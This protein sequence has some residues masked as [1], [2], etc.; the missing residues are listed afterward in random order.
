MRQKIARHIGVTPN[1]N[2]ASLLMDFF[3]LYGNSFNYYQTGVSIINGGSYFPKR[4]RKANEAF[5]ARYTTAHC[6]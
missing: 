6:L 4:M 3:A 2:L 1:W 5:T